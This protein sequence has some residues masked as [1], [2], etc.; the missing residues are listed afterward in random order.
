MRMSSVYKAQKGLIKVS[1][2]TEGNVIKEI[3][4]TGDFFM[5]PEEALPTLECRLTGMALEQKELDHAIEE[6]YLTGVETPLLS[7]EDFVKAVL[8]VKNASKAP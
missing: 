7:K 6:F 1:L 5:L 2:A 3:E 4:I 8:G